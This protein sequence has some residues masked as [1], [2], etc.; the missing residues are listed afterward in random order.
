MYLFILYSCINNQAGNQTRTYIGTQYDKEDLGIRWGFANSSLFPSLSEVQTRCG[1]TQ[2]TG[3][4]R[5][6]LKEPYV[7]AAAFNLD[8]FWLFF[9]RYSGSGSSG[10]ASMRK[11]RADCDPAVLLNNSFNCLN[12]TNSV[13]TH[14]LL[15][16]NVT[17]VDF[18]HQAISQLSLTDSAWW[19]KWIYFAVFYDLQIYF[20]SICYKSD[21]S[22]QAG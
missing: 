3:Q 1:Q 19:L 2:Q 21:G 15:Y 17:I 5:D 16:L 4:S 6:R 18:S 7:V 14:L 8:F 13:C 22:I 20:H 11:V 10:A 9:C 12:G